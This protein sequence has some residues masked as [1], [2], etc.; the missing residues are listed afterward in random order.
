V[1]TRQTYS[2]VVGSQ[3]TDSEGHAFKRLNAALGDMGGPF[4]SQ[5]KWFIGN[6]K[7]ISLESS[8]NFR[9]IDWAQVTAGSG[10]VYPMNPAGMAFPPSMETA[11]I[12]FTAL[13]ATAVARAKPTN[14]GA[15]LA[16]F[17]G[18]LR[19]GLNPFKFNSWERGVDQARRAGSNYLN[20]EFGFQP[21]VK[22]IMSFALAVSS[23]ERVIAQYER[24]A[25]KVVRRRFDFPPSVEIVPPVSVGSFGPYW[26][27]RSGGPN[28]IIPA[29]PV[30]RERVI[31]RRQ[32]FSGA[33]SYCLPAG[34]D[35]RV[36]VN[37]LASKADILLGLS[38]TPEVLWELSP[39]S[40][41]VDWFSNIGDVLS[42]V[43]DRQTDR[44]VMRYGYLMEHTI[45]T[46]TYSRSV[47]QCT[48]YGRPVV[49]DS[50]FK[51]I[52]ETKKRIRA[53]PFGFGVS[54]NSLSP[55]QLSIAAALG[56]TRGP[57]K[58]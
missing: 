30:I 48:N 16:T 52:T 7:N 14:T 38:L 40:W 44:L 45:V 57:R 9:D 10:P 12:A 31:A 5:K 23:A 37:E 35:S 42:N 56:I 36:A 20:L 8:V 55:F 28:A 46:D 17:L 47:T 53:N 24:D 13:G 41:A 33:F 54:W 19:Q 4:Y 25:G 32:W 29:S 11:D 27:D 58:T 51:L 3:V 1:K 34:Y 26:G 15:N 22:D 2:T 21:L 43:S 18:E 49:V 39:W 50:N 6:P